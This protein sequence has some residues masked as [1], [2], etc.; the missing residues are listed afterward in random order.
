M[1]FIEWSGTGT[2]AGINGNKFAPVAVRF[3]GRVEDRNEPGNEQSADSGSNIDRYFLRVEDLTGTL[4]ILVDADGSD[5]GL[6]DPLTITGGDFLIHCTSCAD[7]G[8]GAV[9]S[10]AELTAYNDF[11]RGDSNT[12]GDVDVSDVIYTLG[13][14]VSG[15][16]API[17]QDAA[18]ANDDGSLDLS[19]SIL[20]LSFLYLGRSPPPLPYPSAGRDTTVDLLP[21]ALATDN[22]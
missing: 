8:G 10:L 4:L 9:S 17:C 14:L 19:D 21:C 20:G 12:D 15:G 3:F 6:V 1:N 13:Y 5:D 11:L 18:D 7:G 22:G 16:P 2:V